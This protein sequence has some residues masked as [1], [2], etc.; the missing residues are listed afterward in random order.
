[1]VNFNTLTSSKLFFEEWNDSKK[2]F[3]LAGLISLS[4]M[5]FLFWI[6]VNV[7]E[8]DKSATIYLTMLII[9][10]AIAGF[11]FFFEKGK[12][13]GFLFVGKNLKTL[14]LALIVGGVLAVLLSL[15]KFS[16]LIA[17]LSAIQV[18]SVLVSFIF[19]VLVAPWVEE[20]FFRMF[21]Y[22]NI[23]LML[24]NAFPKRQTL[25]AGLLAVIVTGVLFALFHFAVYGANLNLMFLAFVFST[26]AIVGNRIFESAGF[27]VGLHYV[28]NFLAFGVL[29]KL[30]GGV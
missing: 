5:M 20:K 17:P 18:D 6:M 7:P 3:G 10:T 9:A 27:G 14:F 25:F 28:N 4:L 21:F 8:L 30:F 15:G 1:M 22:P 11:D 19:V 2:L 29:S 23:V 16:I 24:Q 12:V 26:I 13:F